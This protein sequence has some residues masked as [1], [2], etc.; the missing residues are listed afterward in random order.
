MYE[1]KAMHED[2]LGDYV[3]VAPGGCVHAPQRTINTDGVWFRKE[4]SGNVSSAH[5]ECM[6]TMKPSKFSS[7]ADD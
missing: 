2:E 6:P 4:G 3:C 5:A 1:T 7:L